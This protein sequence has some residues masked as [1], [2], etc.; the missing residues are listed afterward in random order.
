VRKEAEVHVYDVE[1]PTCHAVPGAGC[2]SRTGAPMELPHRERNRVIREREA[3]DGGLGEATK[4]GTN[5]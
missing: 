2:V 3:R 1:C 4:A 5:E